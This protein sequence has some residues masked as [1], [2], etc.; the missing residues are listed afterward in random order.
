MTKEIQAINREARDLAERMPAISSIAPPTSEVLAKASEEADRFS[1]HNEGALAYLMDVNGTVI[2]SS[3]R[4]QQDSILGR[5]NASRASFRDAYHGDSGSCF[6]AGFK[7]AIVSYI[8]SYPVFDRSGQVVGVAAIRKPL[9]PEELGFTKLRNV[10]LVDAD[11]LVLFSAAPEMRLR[12]LWPLTAEAKARLANTGQHWQSEAPPLLQSELNQRFTWLVLGGDHYLASRKIINKK[13]WA[14]V[15]MREQEQAFIYR[16]F[17]I[18]VTFLITG[19][20]IA[21]Y[22]M[23][24]R[25]LRTEASLSLKQHQLKDL[26]QTLETVNTCNSIIVRSD[27]ENQLLDAACCT[28]VGIG[29]LELAWVGM[30]VDRAEM[31]LQPVAYHCA[32]EENIDIAKTAWL[33]EVSGPSPAGMA[34]RT[35]EPCLV[36]AESADFEYPLAYR[37][38]LATQSST[39][40]ALPLKNEGTVLGSLSLYSR[41][42]S[43]TTGEIDLYV[44]LADNIAFGLQAR[45]TA[46]QRR[47]AKKALE[48]AMEKAEAA[49]RAKSEFLANMSHEIRTPMNAVIGLSQLAL[50]TKLDAR[51]HDYLTKIKAAGTGLLGIINDI[52]D[53]SKIEAGKLT[54][55]TIPFSLNSVLDNVFNVSTLRAAEEKLELKFEIAPE[56]PQSLV[57]D[58]LRLGQVL[59][60]LVNN[61][62]KF[63]ERG[64][65]TV[66]V[67]VAEWAESAVVVR[68]A[69][70]DTGIGMTEPQL[71]RLFQSFSQADSST[72]RRFGGTGLGLVISKQI[73]E[74]MG[75][76]IGVES[77]PGVGS[78]FIFTA[79]LGIVSAGF[80]KPVGRRRQFQNLRVL[81]VD[82]DATAREI[83]SS[84]LLSWSM[85]VRTAVSGSEALVILEEAERQGTGFDLVLIDWQMPEPNGIET[86]QLI[87]ND[88]RLAVRPQ[89]IIV[90]AFSTNE[91]IARQSRPGIE[92]FLVKPVEPSVLFDTIA[93]I[94]DRD[95]HLTPLQHANAGPSPTPRLQGTRVLLVDDNE[96]NRMIAVEF[97]AEAGVKVDVAVTGT[98]AVAMGL[99]A[100]WRYDAVL[101]DVQMPEM[102]GMEATRR[103]RLHYRSGELPIIAMTAHAMEEER[104]RCF[105]AGM[106][107]HISKP[108]D[109]AVL[110][111]TLSRWIKPRL[112]SSD[113]KPADH[114]E[115]PPPVDASTAGD[116]WPDDL[117]P[118]DLATASHRLLGNRELLRKV[119][120]GFHQGFASTATE[121]DRLISEGR[122]DEVSRLAHNLKSVAGTLEASALTKAAAALEDVLRNHHPVDIAP[123]V[124]TIKRELEPALLAAARAVVPAVL[125]RVSPVLPT[126]PSFDLGEARGLIAELRVQLARNS[127]KTYKVTA[128]LRDVL[129]GLGLDHH[130]NALTIHLDRFDFR[131]AEATLA[132]LEADLPQKEATP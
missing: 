20:I 86:A 50:K 82:D 2:A 96:I 121:L 115:P 106:D 83:L 5:S 95:D 4:V 52:L 108:I 17:G 24:R 43:F 70:R 22:A 100:A 76:S 66:S 21:Y 8:A 104:L 67:A 28:L 53:L 10:Y 58:P 98:Q 1:L 61:A 11:G 65:V 3:D 35:G 107:D 128:S 122:L 14:V 55:E 46:E 91:M 84:T 36:T 118:F 99:E 29:G 120:I 131:G 126:S 88:L 81:V 15:L 30:L 23:F 119:V 110:I 16:L 25:Q 19:L 62:V 7:T 42:P 92:A 103:L 112:P 64:G 56:V 69:V 59:L 9:H 89:I 63:T 48:V 32:D 73:T 12:S 87:R 117:P 79:L 116:D 40:L 26:S 93:T 49:T 124:D 75:G 33:D 71:K 123:L 129:S 85:Q 37:Q 60:N 109:P 18:I 45:R 68:F 114:P 38:M 90:S 72:T 94:F 47:Q 111:E 34:V 127:S 44:N 80:D 130:L 132:V 31:I 77:E 41:S 27:S 51:Q 101:M 6:D 74:L 125:A 39:L 97:L 102:D 113:P 105:D 78:T 54:L 57:G 13:G